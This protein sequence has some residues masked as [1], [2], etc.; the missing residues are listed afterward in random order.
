MAHGP[1]G[2][3]PEVTGVDVVRVPDGRIAARYPFVDGS[4]E[5]PQMKLAESAERFRSAGARAREQHTLMA[6]P[7]IYD[8][9]SVIPMRSAAPVFDHYFRRRPA[10]YGCPCGTGTQLWISRD[11]SKAPGARCTTS[12]A[13]KGVR[14]SNP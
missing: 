4:G 13:G 14:G 9:E 11:A 5:W 6:L 10:H 1:T 12:L 8:S 7:T 3:P 2:A